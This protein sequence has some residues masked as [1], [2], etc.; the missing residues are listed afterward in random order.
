MFQDSLLGRRPPW[1]LDALAALRRHDALTARQ[2]AV[3]VGDD[4]RSVALALDGFVGDG[5]LRQQP[6]KMRH[7]DTHCFALAP[8][9]LLVLQRAGLAPPGRLRPVPVGLHR[10]AHDLERNELGVVL[11]RLDADRHLR[12]ERFVTSSSRI[13]FAA[14]LPHRGQIHRIPLVADAFAVLR[15]GTRVDALLV[16]I[17]MGSVAMERMRAKY[18][19]YV[20]W[21]QGGGPLRQFGL[22]SLRVL[23]LTATPARLERLR[24]AAEDGNQGQGTG[25][26]WFGDLDDVRAEDPGRLLGSHFLRADGPG[27]RHALFGRRA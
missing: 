12:L 10:L 14:H 26:L 27:E 17:D 25:L 7:S 3:V 11:E 16:E 15:V 6:V 5:L 18:R 20:A 4:P 9:G 2:V 24:A 23:T 1:L 22:R 19:G 21:W 8:A 13:G